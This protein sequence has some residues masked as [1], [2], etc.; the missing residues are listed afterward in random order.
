MS[1]L[2]KILLSFLAA[3]SV[4]VEE[5]H[6]D[7]IVYHEYKDYPLVVRYQNGSLRHLGIDIFGYSGETAQEQV[8]MDFIER[9]SLQLLLLNKD[10]ERAF[11][12]DLDGVEA[13]SVFYTPLHRDGFVGFQFELLE[14]KKYK[15][16]WGNLADGDVRQMTFPADYQLLSGKNKIELENGFIGG[17]EGPILLSDQ[18]TNELSALERIGKNLY[19]LQ[20]ECY[21]I[22][23]ITTSR[24]YEKVNGVFNAVQREDH[25]MESLA[26]LLMNPSLAENQ[27]VSLRV[28]KYGYDSEDTVCSLQ[29]LLG[30]CQMDG[31]V[32]YIGMESYDEKTGEMRATL[33]LHNEALGYDHVAKVSANR[34]IFNHADGILD[35]VISVFIPIHNLKSLFS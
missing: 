3:A 15:V 10:T 7:G 12:M 28:L 6:Q 2:L 18:L 24:Y 9:Y 25:P 5:T 23:E 16:I 20:G 21:L 17:L 27:R 8:L 30:R 13:P 32:P 4:P 1:S 26:N 35:M 11:R 34:S 22:P 31:C 33:I 29:R 14:G 19:R